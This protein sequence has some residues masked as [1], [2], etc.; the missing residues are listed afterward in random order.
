MIRQT[1]QKHPVEREHEVC[2]L[3][4]EVIDD[5]RKSVYAYRQMSTDKVAV[6]RRYWEMYQT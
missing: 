1:S 5:D 4:P 2:T 3:R 6:F